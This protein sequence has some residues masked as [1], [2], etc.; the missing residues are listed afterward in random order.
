[1]REETADFTMQRSVSQLLFSY[2]PGKTVDWESGT[3]IVQLTYVR[4][5]SAWDPARAQLVL[6]EVADYLRRW[7]ERGGRV[8][9][10]FPDPRRDGGRFTIGEPRSIEADLLETALQCLSC[11]RLVF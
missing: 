5:A 9:T 1:M 11:S 8:H 6:A 2:L 3:A 10:T 7:R 4:L